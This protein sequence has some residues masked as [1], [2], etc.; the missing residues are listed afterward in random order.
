[1]A[2]SKAVKKSKL[3]FLDI[4]GVMHSSR[5][6]KQ[7]SIEELE[8]M[9]DV[10]GDAFDP[11]SASLINKL[12]AKTGANIVIVSETKDEGRDWAKAFWDSRNM[13]GEVVG[14]TPH[15]TFTAKG[16][17]AQAIVP[18]GTEIQWYLEN[19]HNFRYYDK[20]WYNNIDYAN[21]LK[22]RCTIES[23]VIINDDNDILYEQRSNFV[24]C[25][26]TNGFTQKEYRKAL[27]ILNRKI[28]L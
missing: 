4:A 13:D 12:I 3:I 22:E 6:Y 23:Y 2:K 9:R 20:S 24:E 28:S 1:M 26:N 17:R 25:D 5:L 18:R 8:N 15:L 21:T 16:S 10:Y 27:R 7:H 19:Y 11:L 14:T